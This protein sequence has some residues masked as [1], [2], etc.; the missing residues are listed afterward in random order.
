MRLI[1]LLTSFLFLLP[2]QLLQAAEPD[3]LDAHQWFVEGKRLKKAQKTRKAIIR[4]E[5]SA[6]A[7]MEVLQWKRAIEAYALAGQ[8]ASELE[9]NFEEA[10]RLIKQAIGLADLHFPEKDPV[11]LYVKK[12]FINHQYDQGNY[13]VVINLCRALLPLEEEVYGPGSLQLAETHNLIGISLGYSGQYEQAFAKYQQALAIYEQGLGRDHPAAANT[14]MNMGVYYERQADYDN[15]LSYYEES[16]LI[17]VKH[18]GYDSY[19]NASC[20]ANIGNVYQF[21]GDYQQAG[22]Y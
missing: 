11:C 18:K 21:K 5:K 2:A 7:F 1:W 10:D 17:N 22:A 14:L 19:G 20:L 6:A 4:L 15:A 8:Y 16:R 12:T 13:E 3:S 9:Q